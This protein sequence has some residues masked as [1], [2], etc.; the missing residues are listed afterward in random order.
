MPPAAQLTSFER[1]RTSRLHSARNADLRIPEARRRTRPA[2]RGPM[3]GGPGFGDIEAANDD[4]EIP[5]VEAANDDVEEEAPQAASPQMETGVPQRAQAAKAQAV[6]AAGAA[7]EAQATQNGFSEADAM[8][9]DQIDIAVNALCYAVPV[10]G[11]WFWWNVRMG[12]GSWIAGGNSKF[13]GPFGWG[14]VIMVFLPGGKY[15]GSG[16][17]GKAVAQVLPDFIAH[18]TL[19][20]IDLLFLTGGMTMLVFQAMILYVLY[21]SITDPIGSLTQFG[22]LITSFL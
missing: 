3:F 20:F 18:L 11:H 16:T 7:E 14:D 9:R 8:L 1:D 10:L 17:L 19:V 5:L 21:Q 15:M 12:Y 2:R 4:T 22:G 6:A 13:I